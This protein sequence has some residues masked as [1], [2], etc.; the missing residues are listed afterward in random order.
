MKLSKLKI[1][2]CL[3]A[4][5]VVMPCASAP[6]STSLSSSL[7]TFS[8][9]QDTP[10]GHSSHWMGPLTLPQGRL[11]ATVT[12]RDPRPTREWVPFVAFDLCASSSCITRARLDVFFQPEGAASLSVE[13]DGQKPVSVT[14][15]GSYSVGDSILVVLEWSRSNSV[16]AQLNEGESQRLPL[17]FTPDNLRIISGSADVL[18]ESVSIR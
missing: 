12:I 4:F 13:M 2:C 1:L 9:N 7:A 3:P 11:T 17:P 5:L 8:V 18:I 6:A 14:L 16:R 15:P 10:G